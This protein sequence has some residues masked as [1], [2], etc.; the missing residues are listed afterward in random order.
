MLELLM[1]SYAPF[2]SGWT[3]FIMHDLVSIATVLAVGSMA[4][5]EDAMV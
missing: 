2:G 5:A 3:H 1:T 4:W